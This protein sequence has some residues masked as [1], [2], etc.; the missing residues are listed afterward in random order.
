MHDIRV[1]QAA[2]GQLLQKC[3]RC[4]S[5]LLLGHVSRHHPEAVPR[6]FAFRRAP[7]DLRAGIERT[8]QL[9]RGEY[10]DRIQ[11]VRELADGPHPVAN[12]GEIDQ[13][14]MNLRGVRESGVAFAIPSYAFM[15][16]IIG[17]VAWGVFRIATGAMSGTAPISKPPTQSA[18]TSLISSTIKA[19]SR[20]APSGCSMVGLLSK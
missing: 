11:V 15:I 18:F 8:L 3:A 4:L 12:A 10:R 19:A 7:V 5:A 13:V 16:G 14:L 6:L 20:P 1:L 9:L 2:R 17:M